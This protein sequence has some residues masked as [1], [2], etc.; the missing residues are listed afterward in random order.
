MSASIGHMIYV[1]HS[2]NKSNVRHMNTGQCVP[3]S[4]K[5][6]DHDTCGDSG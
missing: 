6:D 5:R 3:I 2:H 1:R 4:N